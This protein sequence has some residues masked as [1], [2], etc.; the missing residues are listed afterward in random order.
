MKFRI[1]LVVLA[2]AA[3]CLVPSCST[4]A[5]S[6]YRTIHE[7][8]INGDLNAVTQDLNGY[9]GDLSLTDDAG[10]TPLH[11]AAIHCRTNIVVLLLD[12]GAKVDARAKGDDTPLHLA[13][14]AG[15]LDAVAILLQHGA[16]INARDSDGHT[17]MTRA[18]EWNQDA[19]VNFLRDHG[20]K[21]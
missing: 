4:K 5:H 10:Q 8:V 20:G 2:I 13:A 3:A 18:R 19:V 9:P 11:L 1:L 14:Q 12:R 6:D 17:P 7:L 15:C 21:E 16:D